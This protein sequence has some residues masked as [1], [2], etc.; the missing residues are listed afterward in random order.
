MKS[1]TICPHCGEG[2][3]VLSHHLGKE[4]RCPSCQRSSTA[5]EVP[6]AMPV[7]KG[8]KPSFW[9]LDKGQMIGVGVVFFFAVVVL[10]SVFKGSDERE[11]RHS[12][13]S[14]SSDTHGAWAYMQIHVE[15]QLKAP[16]G[17]SFPSGGH[18]NVKS[19]GNDRYRISSYVDSQNSFGVSVRNHFSGVIRDN[20]GSWTVESFS[21]Q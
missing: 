3:E 13:W 20:G 18:R 4:V 8:A 12:G 15:G 9:K 5:K 17:A 2:F 14:E 10:S 6:P 1:R 19:L 7:A 16:K 11:E 21:F